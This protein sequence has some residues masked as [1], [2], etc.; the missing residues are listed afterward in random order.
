MPPPP[1]VAG[2]KAARPRST[3]A[4]L[5]GAIGAVAMVLVA[6]GSALPWATAS[7]EF[8]SVSK[9]GLS[10]DGI[11]TIVVG[12]L[13]LAFFAAGI[14]LQARWPFVTALILSLIV[15]AVAI[16]DTVDIA[17][18]V[19]V[20]IGVILC[21]IGGCIGIVAAIVGIAAPRRA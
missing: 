11:I 6:I 16:Y 17:G 1:S 12:L 13:A 8:Y 2:G 14:A 4:M 15:S 10:G 5:F 18:Q 9:N 21:I 19:S 7:S 3:T 20:G